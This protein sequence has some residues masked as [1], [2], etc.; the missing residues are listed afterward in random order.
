MYLDILIAGL[1]RRKLNILGGNFSLGADHDK[2]TIYPNKTPLWQIS[3]K[4]SF[5]H[6]FISNFSENR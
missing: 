3:L 6:S 5:Q 1:S 2:E 4:L